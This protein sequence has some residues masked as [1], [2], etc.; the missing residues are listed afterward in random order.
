MDKNKKGYYII[1]GNPY[2]KYI[3]EPKEEIIISNMKI[4]KLVLPF[5]K[6]IYCGYNSLTELSIPNGCES[7]SC[8]NNNLN[9]LILSDTCTTVFCPFNKLTE[10]IITKN[11]KEIVCSY[12]CLTKI[13]I[14]I[15]IDSVVCDNNPLPQ[16]II[17]LFESKDPVKITLANNMQI[18]NNLQ[19]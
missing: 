6:A 11:C 4:T 1:E 19:R 14:P 10:L 18:A 5:C 7:V 13:K 17:D 12:N 3:L 9:K 2:K 8:T 16:V 15:T